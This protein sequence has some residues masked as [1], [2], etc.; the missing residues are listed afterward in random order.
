MGSIGFFEVVVIN[1]RLTLQNI[2]ISLQNNM[3]IGGGALCFHI[4]IDLSQEVGAFLAVMKSYGKASHVFHSFMEFYM[5][6]FALSGC[7]IT[8][9]SAR[10]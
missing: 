6:I 8:P 5:T 7:N 3:L 10:F 1:G 2:A 9:A 4:R